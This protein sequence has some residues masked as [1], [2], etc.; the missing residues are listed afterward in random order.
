MF[1]RPKVERLPGR[2]LRFAGGGHSMELLH[3]GPNEKVEEPEEPV[4]LAETN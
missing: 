3:L 1:A 2:R 4:D